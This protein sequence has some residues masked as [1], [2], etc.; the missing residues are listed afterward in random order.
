M[1]SRATWLAVAALLMAGLASVL[2]LR[3]DFA[4]RSWRRAA[5]LTLAAVVGFPADTEAPFT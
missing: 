2:S 5:T 1:F 4:A 3:Q